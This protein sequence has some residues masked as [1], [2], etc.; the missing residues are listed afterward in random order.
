MELELVKSHT[1]K[2]KL[3]GEAGVLRVLRVSFA[4]RAVRGVK[5]KKAPDGAYAP[6]A[7]RISLGDGTAEGG[8]RVIAN[9]SDADI[10]K[11]PYSN[12]R[13]HRKFVASELS[14]STSS[15]NRRKRKRRVFA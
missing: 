14:S 13:Q 7:A 15:T 9:V 4:G 1:K 10:F 3:R 5:G 6:G 12:K 11:S 8:C 2:I